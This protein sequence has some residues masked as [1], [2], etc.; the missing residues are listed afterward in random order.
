MS[1]DSLDE[2]GEFVIRIP[3]TGQEIVVP[4]ANMRE[5]LANGWIKLIIGEDG[6]KRYFATEKG[7]KV[8][9]Q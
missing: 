2:D 4:H 7:K 9:R 8:V 5:M 6:E 3:T 1:N